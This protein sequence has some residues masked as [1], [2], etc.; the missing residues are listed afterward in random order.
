MIHIY[1]SHNAFSLRLTMLTALLVTAMT[2]LPQSL[3]AQN[4][5]ITTTFTGVTQDEYQQ[6]VLTYTSNPAGFDWGYAISGYYQYD[7]NFSCTTDTE[8]GGVHFS[9]DS[10]SFEYYLESKNKVIGS[11]A[12]GDKIAEIDVVM[13]QD[14]RLTPSFTVGRTTIGNAGSQFDTERKISIYADAACDVESSTVGITFRTD[15]YKNYYTNGLTIKAVRLYNL[16]E[17]KELVPAVTASNKEEILGQTSGLGEE[18]EAYK[19]DAVVLTADSKALFTFPNAANNDGYYEEGS[20]KLVLL[21]TPQEDVPADVPGLPAFNKAFTGVTLLIPAGDGEITVEAR[22]E[23]ESQ[24]NVQI[25]SY[26]ARQFK[27]ADFAEHVV[28]YVVNR[29]TY[30]YIF[31]TGALGEASSAGLR[32]PGRKMANT[33]SLK[34]VKVKARSVASAPPAPATPKTLTKDDIHIVDGHIIV[35]DPSFASIA[36]DAFDDVRDADVTYVDLSKTS[37]TGYNFYRDDDITLSNYVNCNQKAIVLVPFGNNSVDENIVIGGI[38][39]NLQLKKDANF[40]LPQD[41]QATEVTLDVDF[42][43]LTDKTASVVLPFGLDDVQ[44]AQI[45]TFYQFKNIADGKV[46]MQPV[47]T[48]E[49]N[50]PYLLKASVAALSA[51]MVEVKASVSSAGARRAAT[52]PEFV[53]V[54]E[55]TT[56][57]SDAYIYKEGQ[58]ELVTTAT[59]LNAFQAYIKAPGATVTPLTIAFITSGIDM[60]HGGGV[61]GAP[62]YY[63]LQGRRVLYPKK[64]LYI[65]NGNKVI[66]K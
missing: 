27:S 25:G 23:G 15:D 32:A 1:T 12:K 8:N 58:F 41:I 4:P 3:R 52:D 38:C 40:D 34:K 33:T 2:F 16:E 59:T 35:D 47:A 43:A 53:G 13:D 18:I 48:P 51:E 28:R 56:L 9:F 21:N 19:D 66:I 11:F 6:T 30:V 54:F 61:D 65:L 44:A 42:S 57:S 49:A 55:P 17:V 45:G 5:T 10:Q 64:G 46:N 37:I 63:D 22:T 31:K 50:K 62:V 36:A 24:L 26:T 14:V 7:S 39:R 29:P 60:V 20:D